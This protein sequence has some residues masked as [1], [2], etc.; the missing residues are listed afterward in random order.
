MLTFEDK[1]F[2]STSRLLTSLENMASLASP[3]RRGNCWREQGRD[4]LLVVRHVLPGAHDA[5]PALPFI[6]LA[7]WIVSS[8]P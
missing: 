2:T 1:D 5:R 8:C 7:S 4:R 3:A 6:S